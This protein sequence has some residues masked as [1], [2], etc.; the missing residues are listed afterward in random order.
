[1]WVPGGD[2]ARTQARKDQPPRIW[3]VRLSGFFLGKYEVTWA[4]LERFTREI[5]ARSP[6]P[7]YPVTPEDPVHGVNWLQA[8]AY[9]RHYGLSLPSLQQ[10]LHAAQPDGARYPWGDAP[11]TPQHANL[12]GDIDGFERTAPVGSFPLSR[13]RCGAYD[14]LGNVAEWVYDWYGEEPPPDGVDLVLDP[15]GPAQPRSRE[16]A[17]KLVRG[18]SFK[19]AP[20][21]ARPDEGPSAGNLYAVDDVGFRVALTHS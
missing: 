18:G 10:F 3:T 14:L 4:Q 2:H 1:V 20:D 9:C 19:T 17:Y 6:R 5:G 7:A 12:A 13:A 11:P 21:Q 8:D 16:L 15:R